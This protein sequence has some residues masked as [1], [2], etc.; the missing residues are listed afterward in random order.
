MRIYI[1]ISALALALG[2]CAKSKEARCRAF[3]DRAAECLEDDG[4]DPRLRALIQD[5]MSDVGRQMCEDPDV[6]AAMTVVE[7]CTD[8]PDCA[9]FRACLDRH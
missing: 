3:Y 1:V 4:G 8:E 9:T 7:P 6:K 2:A 5:K